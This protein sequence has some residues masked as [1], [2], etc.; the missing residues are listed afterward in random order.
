MARVEPPPEEWEE[1]AQKRRRQAKGG[2]RERAVP[3]DATRLPKAP[4]RP[5]VSFR[6]SPERRT[7]G[8]RRVRK[9]EV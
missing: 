1:E 7:A 2:E 5:A 9:G 6:L 8:A 4:R 3:R